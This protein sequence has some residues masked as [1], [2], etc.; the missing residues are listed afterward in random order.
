M[1]ARVSIL[2]AAIVLAGVA[3]SGVLSANG[4]EFFN[5]QVDGPTVLYYAG[6]IK[7]SQGNVVDKVMVTISAKN[8]GMSAMAVYPVAAIAG[9]MNSAPRTPMYLKIRDTTNACSS[10]PST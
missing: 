8:V 7:D 4:V 2:A 9:R 10:R 3:T 1:K 5:A 6:H